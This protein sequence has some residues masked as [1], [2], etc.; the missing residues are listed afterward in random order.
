MCVV[1]RRIESKSVSMLKQNDLK[2]NPSSPASFKYKQRGLIVANNNVHR[3][4]M[5]K[6]QKYELCYRISSSTN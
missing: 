1:G 6:Y 4:L 5:K 2:G 3:T